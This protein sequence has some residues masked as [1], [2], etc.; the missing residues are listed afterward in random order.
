MERK[1][2]GGLSLKQ[3]VNASKL[4]SVVP[5]DFFSTHGHSLGRDCLVLLI[6]FCLLQLG[7]IVNA[8]DFNTY[9]YLRYPNCCLFDCIGEKCYV[10]DGIAFHPCL[11][12]MLI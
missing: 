12:C 3:K 5:G 8:A 4:N 6:R 10:A 11:R 7:E 2:G 9:C 1:G